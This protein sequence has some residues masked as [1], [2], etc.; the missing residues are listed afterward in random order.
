MTIMST[1]EITRDRS[2]EDNSSSREKESISFVS[3]P[4]DIVVHIL[5]C[6]NIQ[7]L[8]AVSWVCH[9]WR[10]LVFECHEAFS[11]TT[12][13]QGGTEEDKRELRQLLSRP[14]VRGSMQELYLRMMYTQLDQSLLQFTS[15]FRFPRLRKLHIKEYAFANDDA[16]IPALKNVSDTLSDL[17]ISTSRRRVIPF[18]TIFSICSNLQFFTYDH[19]AYQQSDILP[20]SDL[21]MPP[22]GLTQLNLKFRFRHAVRDLIKDTLRCCPHLVK[23][24]L[25]DCGDNILEAIYQHCKRL[26]TLHV[27]NRLRYSGNRSTQEGI[28][29]LD[30]LAVH[31]CQK[32]ITMVAPYLRQS[33]QT[34]RSLHVGLHPTIMRH[35]D[36]L[37]T[38]TF[39]CL[40][41]LGI[42][43]EDLSDNM[44]PAL[45]IAHLPGLKHLHFSQCT[46]VPSVVF[47]EVAGLNHLESLTMSRASFLDKG[48]VSNMLRSFANKK[49]LK[50]VSIHNCNFSQFDGFLNLLVEVNSLEEIS[51]QLCT[52]ANNSLVGRFC[53][54]L[55]YHPSIRTITFRCL[56]EVTDSTL[57]QLSALETLRRLALIHMDH[58]T[59]QAIS[60]FINYRPKVA[61]KVSRRL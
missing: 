13:F 39:P 47:D 26:E 52:F 8:I 55:R 19:K 46:S 6:L 34:L 38:I 7:D 16:L 10:T 18:K 11:I 12:L 60:D 36:E 3:L 20:S 43:S 5:T 57:H 33:S 61:L 15:S 37:L 40:I 50:S 48:A 32:S 25:D 56:P 53:E 23:L 35:W 31:S 59:E 29:E 27:R 51:I 44:F 2:R 45:L 54:K 4:Y 49:C 28:L 58:V 1:R 17:L 21:S 41:S 42:S 24:T 30:T 14:S 9:S 22:T